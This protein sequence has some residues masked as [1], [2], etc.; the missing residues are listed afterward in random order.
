MRPATTLD[1]KGRIIGDYPKP[2][3]F[4][5]AEF[6]AQPHV[7]HSIAESS[8][9]QTTGR[10]YAVEDGI[11]RKGMTKIIRQVGFGD[12]RHHARLWRARSRTAITLAPSA[13]GTI[14]R[15]SCVAGNPFRKSSKVVGEPTASCKLKLRTMKRS[16]KAASNSSSASRCLRRAGGSTPARSSLAIRYASAAVL[17]QA[18]TPVSSATSQLSEIRRCRIVRRSPDTCRTTA[19]SALDFSKVNMMQSPFRGLK[20]QDN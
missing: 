8:G 4:L 9:A 10:F 18:T 1:Q 2:P 14:K 17:Q 7:Q 3:P 13:P 11:L 15:R 6:P 19:A 20:C 16:S 5:A 12:W